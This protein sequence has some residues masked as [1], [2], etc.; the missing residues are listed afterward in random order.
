MMLDALNRCH[1]L[2]SSKN[3]KAAR[4]DILDHM[5]LRWL[6]SLWQGHAQQHH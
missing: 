5:C 3:K 2:I 4:L 6:R 1:S